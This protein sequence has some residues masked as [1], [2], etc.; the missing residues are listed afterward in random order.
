MVTRTRNGS[1]A[2]ASRVSENCWRYTPDALAFCT[3]SGPAAT[4]S[5]A[6]LLHAHFQMAPAHARYRGEMHDDR[7]IRQHLAVEAVTEVHGD[8]HL[9]AG[10]R[11]E[12]GLNAR[13]AGRR[14][15]RAPRRV[16][17]AAEHPALA[18]VRRSRRRRVGNRR[19]GAGCAGGSGGATCGAGLSQPASS[20]WLTRRSRRPCAIVPSKL[21]S[22]H[23]RLS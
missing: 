2:P 1:G 6:A 11:G 9:G 10:Y 13:F 22:A 14:R 3:F 5:P 21:V 4:C 16:R 15:F 8:A 18:P 19:R 12:H 17:W 7:L 20:Q 23:D